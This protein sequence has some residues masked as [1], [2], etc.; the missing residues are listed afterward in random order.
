MLAG[1]IL[2]SQRFI[3]PRDQSE[4]N[5]LTT[6]LGVIVGSGVV[7][8]A[9]AVWLTRYLPSLPMLNRLTL[10]PPTSVDVAATDRALTSDIDPQAAAIP[11]IAI[12]TQGVARSNLRPAGK[13]LL[14]DQ[15]LDV[16]ADATIIS[17][18]TAIE[19]VEISGKQILVRPLASGD[20]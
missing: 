6:S 1:V 4:I 3:I 18:G 12:G 15:L 16:T 17:R 20:S 14:G 5:T 19:V 13:A 2:A 7:F 8:I 11:A 10:A 9:A